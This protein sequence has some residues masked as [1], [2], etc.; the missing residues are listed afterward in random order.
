MDRSYT[1][2]SHCPLWP[3]LDDDTC[4]AAQR[5]GCT[6]NAKQTKQWTISG[7]MWNPATIFCGLTL[8]KSCIVMRFYIIVDHWN[9]LKHMDPTSNALDYQ[10]MSAVA[11]PMITSFIW[12]FDLSYLSS[13]RPSQASWTMGNGEG[14]CTQNDAPSGSNSMWRQS[15]I[16]TWYALNG[17]HEGPCLASQFTFRLMLNLVHHISYYVLSLLFQCSSIFIICHQCSSCNALFIP[18]FHGPFP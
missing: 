1:H 12:Y 11:F 10:L 9:I 16:P 7:K 17:D 4:Q 6:G 15:S 2:S 8:G 13:S 3:F 5:V 14:T 18:W